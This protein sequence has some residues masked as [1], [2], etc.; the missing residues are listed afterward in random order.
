MSSCGLILLLGSRYTKQDKKEMK[1]IAWSENKM[2]PVRICASSKE[3]EKLCSL[4]MLNI[5]EE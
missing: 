2:L 5:G 3:K 1:H 4:A